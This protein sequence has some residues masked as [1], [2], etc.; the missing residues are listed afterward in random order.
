MCSSQNCFLFLRLT[1]GNFDTSHHWAGASLWAP[2]VTH[3]AVHT[4]LAR[5]Y[6]LVDDSVRWILACSSRGRFGENWEYRS[7][8]S[9]PRVQIKQ[10]NSETSE[11]WWKR[12]LAMETTRTKSFPSAV[13]FQP[14]WPEQT[15]GQLRFAEGRWIGGWEEECHGDRNRER[16]GWGRRGQWNGRRR[17]CL[18]QPSTCC[19]PVTSLTSK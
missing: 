11:H 16:W 14:Q 10:T 13:G 2:T 6:M 4:F 19:A 9:P 1:K 3:F 7:C 17:R 15:H 12:L 8:W 5:T 18:H